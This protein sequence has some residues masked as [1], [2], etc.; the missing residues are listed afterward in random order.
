MNCK[1]LVSL[2]VLMAFVASVGAVTW[3]TTWMFLANDSND[4]SCG[5][6]DVMVSYAQ[7]DTSYLYLRLNT[8]N[9]PN[10]D[11]SGS[12]CDHPLYKWF[13][14]QT[15]DGYV[16]GQAIRNAEWMLA[17]GDINNDHVGEIYLIPLTPQCPTG[18]IN[19]ANY[20]I[21]NT[22]IA[23][24]RIT[25]NYLDMAIK[26]SS[27]NN[28][29]AQTLWWITD[30]NDNNICQQ[31]QG[32]ADWPNYGGGQGPFI[33][34]P[35]ISLVKSVTPSSAYPGDTVTFTVIANN[36]GQTYLNI[37][38]GDQLPSD[39]TYVDGSANYAP[40]SVVGNDIVWYLP[41][42]PNDTVRTIT[43]DATVN[44]EAGSV[45]NYA[46]VFGEYTSASNVSA[47][48]IATLEILGLPPVEPYINV[49]K[50]A[51]PTDVMPGEN[52]TLNITMTGGGDPTITT[53]P[54]D[55][56]LVIDRSISMNQ[57]I[58]SGGVPIHKL[59]A[60]KAGAQSFVNI[61]DQ[62]AQAGLVSYASTATLNSSL[63]LMT[64]SNK[65]ALNTVINS[66][67][68]P[69]GSTNMGAAI[70]AAV[71]ELSENGNGGTVKFI[72]LLTDGM[73]T[74]SASGCSGSDTPRPEDYAYARD[75]ASAA[76]TAGYSLYAIGFGDNSSING[77]FL[78]EISGGRYYYAPDADKLRQ[79]YEGIANNIS[80]I[81]A[82]TLIVTDVLPPNVNFEGPVPILNCTPGYD[83]AT[84]T[85]SCT[86]SNIGID[87]TWSLIFNVSI[88]ESGIDIPTNANFSYAYVAANGSNQS[89]TAPS[90][91]VNVTN[92]APVIDSMLAT[93]NP[94][95]REE[96]VT[97][98]ASATD[99]NG[100]NLTYYWD[101][102]D[103]N[104][105]TGTNLTHA[106]QAEGNYT[107][108]LI[109]SDGSLNDSQTLVVVVVSGCQYTAWVDDACTTNST[110]RQTRTDD[111]GYSYCNVLEQYVPNEEQCGCVLNDASLDCVSPGLRE[112]YF[113][114]NWG[115]C[116]PNYSDNIT[117]IACNSNYTCDGFENMVD[118]CFDDGWMN[119]S[120]TCRDQYGN[121]YEE[122]RSV[123]NESCRCSASAT[124]WLC[125]SPG[126]ANA[127][128]DLWN[129]DY[130]SGSYV[131]TESN[132]TC[133]SD[134]VCGNW[135][136][137]E[138]GCVDDGVM[139]QSMTCFD[140]YGNNYTNYTTTADSSCGCNA[141][142]SG[143]LCVSDGFANV[144]YDL[145]NFDYCSGSYVLTQ[146]NETCSCQ[147]SN[148]TN[149]ECVGDGLM[150]QTRTGADYV[151][152][153]DTSRQV[154]SEQCN[155]VECEST[156]G[157]LSEYYSWSGHGGVFA[158]GIGLRPEASRDIVV[159]LPEGA[160][161]VKAFMYW[162]AINQNGAKNDF[163]AMTL[164]G[165]AVTGDEIGSFVNQGPDYCV[166]PVSYR[167]DVTDLVTGSGTY[168][169]NGDISNMFDVEGAE[170]VVV[171]S[172]EGSPNVRV[173]INDGAGNDRFNVATTFSGFASASSANMIFIG[174]GGGPANSSTND[175]VE[176]LFND[177]SLSTTSWDQSDGHE[178]DTDA[179]DV[180]AYVSSEDTSGTAQI[181][182]QGLLNMD[183]VAGVL[184]VTEAEATP[185]PS[186]S[187]SP[188][189]TPTPVPSCSENEHMVTVDG[190]IDYLDVGNTDSE[191]THALDGWSAANISGG[192]GGCN[193][194]AGCSY[195]Q[196][197]EPVESTCSDDGRNAT[198]TLNVGEGR[199]ADKLRLRALDGMSNYDSFDVY[200]DGEFLAHYTDTVDGVELWNTLEYALANKTGTITVLLSATDEIWPLCGTYGQVAFDWADIGGFTCEANTEPSP[201]PS[202]SPEPTATPTPTPETPIYGGGGGGQDCVASGTCNTP[203]PPAPSVQAENGAI[204]NATPTPT[205]EPAKLESGTNTTVPRRNY[206]VYPLT[207]PT[208]TPL[209]VEFATPTPGA[210]TGFASAFS[211][212][213]S[214]GLFILA[215]IAAVLA[216]LLKPPKLFD[217]AKEKTSV[218]KFAV[219]GLGAF[220]L[221]YV[222]SYFMDACQAQMIAL[223]EDI[224]VGGALGYF[225]YL[226]KK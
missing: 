90:P 115:Y 46:N 49:S 160:T 104:N 173:M 179:F 5:N 45:T 96:N 31:P 168:T 181:K 202:P 74:C 128:Y 106:F 83:S 153:T 42:V 76:A 69:S 118:G 8:R 92:V 148:W 40:Q 12:S 43:F 97:F 102:G 54:T 146:T 86:R 103:G 147:Y 191:A 24:T 154:E 55:T 165:N 85:I 52:I 25:G 141:S 213:C 39:L 199:Y 112:H 224:I 188:S 184:V 9:A 203:Q 73:P 142:A 35:G 60:A 167:A 216:Y 121:S 166:L 218:Y 209:P 187:P 130:C 138:N 151:Y 133:D 201:S 37:T 77:T 93:P 174:G 110:M 132:S 156:A 33:P 65:S 206:H 210:I 197:L 48:A 200:V 28:V 189:P 162:N 63:A 131:L 71:A 225:K 140:Q 171:Y 7:I 11:P 27:I 26:L 175:A 1:K 208:P 150:G 205:P 158:D 125:V 64:D 4:L 68:S 135:T 113:T 94:A 204:Y 95:D 21:T 20:R 136:N 88:N 157:A 3:P 66:L 16:Q 80:N 196:I 119:Q 223:A 50:T 87:E 219:I 111:S 61:L 6:M 126:F 139:N 98:E 51:Y 108:T 226:K 32:N 56:V 129:F 29:G 75:A 124:N 211:G 109:V 193:G 177:N 123:E 137:V 91:L 82:G 194:G 134:Y 163:S 195:R 180:S 13:L 2:F 58:T 143:S 198:F 220:A 144:T 15:G 176:S 172:D 221:P 38:V 67:P 30:K 159:T 34:V 149:T 207:T 62:T 59:D 183:W 79:I 122:Y 22:S 178:W 169:V 78:E 185:T 152:C 44:A 17:T 101:F 18:S 89:G 222:A 155:A 10:Y 190:A 145:W 41:S 84:R 72:V 161:V 57:F 116:G 214:A 107:V 170:L 23:D 105:A 81:A 47:S 99:P 215:L 19:W 127:T 120:Q 36:T 117:D 164:N 14:D 212:P 182:G 100:D 70:N 53:M 192:Y 217:A 186:P 114:W